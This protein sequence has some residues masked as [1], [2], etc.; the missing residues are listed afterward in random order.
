[1]ASTANFI[2][3]AQWTRD[4][5]SQLFH[6]QHDIIEVDMALKTF[7][8]GWVSCSV[9]ALVSRS[10]KQAYLSLVS[11]QSSLLTQF[12]MDQPARI[13]TSQWLQL[14]SYTHFLPTAQQWV[15][16]QF[17]W[18]MTKMTKIIMMLTL[19]WVHVCTNTSTTSKPYIEV[20]LELLQLVY[21]LWSTSFTHQYIYISSHSCY[22]SATMT[23]TVHHIPLPNTTF[24]NTLL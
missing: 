19:F 13:K 20:R 18:M 11:L 1:M 4:S 7:C 9:H 5:S 21:T 14:V 17:F 8:N 16:W 10:L 15:T 2:N 23:I 12:K 6:A 24:I 22:S 3:D